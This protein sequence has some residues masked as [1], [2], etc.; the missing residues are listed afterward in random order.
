MEIDSASTSAEV[1]QSL[2]EEIGLK[3]TFGFSLYISFF[4][5]VA[6]HFSFLE[7]FCSSSVQR[8]CHAYVLCSCP[9]MWSLSSCGKH[10]LDAVSVC[11]QEMR[12]QGGE[13]KDTPWMLSLRKEIFSP[14]HNCSLDPISTDLIYKQVIKGV[15][16]GDYTCEKV[17]P[18][19][20][21]PFINYPL[22]TVF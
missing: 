2:A 10:V 21:T 8:S 17:G 22:N 6:F 13:E 4:D 9:Q 18:F 20:H 19:I 3:D 14:W 12:R 5:K 15:K 7:V 16:S 11:E 1:C